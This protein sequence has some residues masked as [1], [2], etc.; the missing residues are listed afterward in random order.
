ML[1]LERAE[2]TCSSDDPM[3]HIPDG[4]FSGALHECFQIVLRGVSGWKLASSLATHPCLFGCLLLTRFRFSWGEHIDHL[5]K[6]ATQFTWLLFGTECIQCTVVK[7]NFIQFTLNRLG[8]AMKKG[9]VLRR[10]HTLPGLF[11]ASN[12]CSPIEPSA[13][14]QTSR[15]SK[16]SYDYSLFST[17]LLSVLQLI[18]RWIIRTTGGHVGPMSGVKLWRR[19]KWRR[20]RQHKV[21][22]CNETTN[23]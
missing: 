10:Q 6:A 3:Q 23:A 4:V 13:L 8:S 17:W 11:A 20:R 21:I 22:V 19:C 18:Q 12:D 2:Y 1:S 5:L 7:V 9:E 16:C 15:N 14:R